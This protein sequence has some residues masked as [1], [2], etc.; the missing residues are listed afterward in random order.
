[1][2]PTAAGRMNAS[3]LHEMM[4]LYG[5]DVVFILGSDIRRDPTQIRD[6]C[7]TFLRVIERS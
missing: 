1:M 2:F 6:A 5:S 4:T 3:R 7:G